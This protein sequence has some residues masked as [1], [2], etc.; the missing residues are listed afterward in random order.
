MYYVVPSNFWLVQLPFHLRNWQYKCVDGFR[1]TRIA[2][3]VAQP[4]LCHNE[5]ITVTV[6]KSA[7]KLG[8]LL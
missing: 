1:V 6:E 2:Q 4:L 7:K 3:N 5:C 8:L